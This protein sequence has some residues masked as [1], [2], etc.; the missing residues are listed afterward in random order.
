M[1]TVFQSILIPGTE[2]SGMADL[3]LPA[4]LQMPD[5]GRWWVDLEFLDL[6]TGPPANYSSASQDRNKNK[7]PTLG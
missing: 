7:N 2:F 6:A 1:V 4:D 3:H 5:F